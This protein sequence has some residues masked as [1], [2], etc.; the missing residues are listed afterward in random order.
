[1]ITCDKIIEETKNI[2]TKSTST[3]FYFLFAFQLITIALVITVSIYW[4]LVK[5]R[6]KQKS[7]PPC[8]YTVKR[9]WILKIYHKMEDDGK[10][11]KI[12]IIIILKIVLV[13]ISMT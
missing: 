8:Y 3:Y 2:L 11:K 10:L 12:I 7:L 5:Y 1:M 9:N 6:A 4:Y 13:L